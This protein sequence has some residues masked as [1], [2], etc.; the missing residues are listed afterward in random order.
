MTLTVLAFGVCSE[1]A[2]HRAGTRRRDVRGV[3]T[4]DTRLVRRVWEGAVKTELC[5]SARKVRVRA[6]RSPLGMAGG[7]Q[8]GGGHGVPVHFRTGVSL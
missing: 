3:V 8:E 4:A 1:A 5:N 7:R 6:Q 2:Q